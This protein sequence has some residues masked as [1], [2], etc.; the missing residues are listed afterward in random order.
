M[1]KTIIAALAAAFMIPF[2]AM[3]DNS[4]AAHESLWNAIPTVG[5]STS[6]NNPRY[7]TAGKDSNDGVYHSYERHISVCQDNG[8]P[9]G[10][11]VDWTANDLDTLRHEAHHIIQDCVRSRLGDGNLD[12]IFGDKDDLVSFIS[13][14]LTR[15]QIEKIIK[16]YAERGLNEREI[17]MEL[18]AFATASD[19]DASTIEEKLLTTCPV[20]K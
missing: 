5:V 9:G 20:V 3:A 17:Y 14:S 16:T 18:E 19:I 4:F 6:L 2:P 7:C 1:K 13:S 11:Q 12:V 15:S 8:T 10:P